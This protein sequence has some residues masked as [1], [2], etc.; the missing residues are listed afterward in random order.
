MNVVAVSSYTSSRTN[1]VRFERGDALLVGR[2]D[3]DYPGWIWVTTLSGAEGWAPE[4]YI[5]MSTD[6][7]G[8]ATATYSA[9]EL[10]TKEGQRLRVLMELA[11]WLWVENE[12]G[13]TGWVP[14][15]T[16]RPA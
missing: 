2:K 9:E 8:V 11:G 10:D 4:V 16:T 15:H 6:D 12:R 7:H 13:K 3:A 14:K 5:A 1:P